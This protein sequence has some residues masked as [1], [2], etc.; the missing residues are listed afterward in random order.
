VAEIFRAEN[1]E[2]GC[3]MLARGRD[4]PFAGFVLRRMLLRPRAAGL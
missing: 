3:E 2:H 1:V 4:R